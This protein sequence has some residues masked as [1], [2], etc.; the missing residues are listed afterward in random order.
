[1]KSPPRPPAKPVL[2]LAEKY[3]QAQA[4]LAKWSMLA[5]APVMDPHA[6]CIAGRG[7]SLEAS[8][9]AKKVARGYAKIVDALEKALLKENGNQLPEE[10]QARL[11]QISKAAASRGN[12][13]L[14]WSRVL[15]TI[16]LR[17]RR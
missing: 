7:L 14:S 6:S 4:D 13:G 3:A 1:M 17:L 12:K 15:R 9:F 2:S 10:L 16:G 5:T 8:L 11:A